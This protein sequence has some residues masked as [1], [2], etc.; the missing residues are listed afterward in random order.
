[1][2]IRVKIGGLEVAKSPE[3]LETILGSCVALMLYDRGKKIGGMAHIMLPHTDD[4]NVRDPGKYANTAVPALITKMTV[5]GARP[6]KLVA[7][8]AGGAAMFK[9]S[10]TMNIGK[11]NVE[12]TKKEL[13]KYKIRI[14][15]EDVGGEGSRTVKFFLKDGKVVVNHR[16]K[17]KII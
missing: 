3:V 12:A 10:N 4:P 8:I 7:K 13:S 2:V 11:K 16:G 14:V 9:T 1:M 5:V 6:N 17:T 15:G